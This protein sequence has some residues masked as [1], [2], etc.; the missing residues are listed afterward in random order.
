MYFPKNRIKTG[1]N[2][3]GELLIKSTNKQYFGPYFKTFGGKYYAGNTPNHAN[4]VELIYPQVPPVDFSEASGLV[5]DSR[6]DSGIKNRIL[7]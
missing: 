2:S 5:E 7:F 4:S 3:N 1:F 6:F